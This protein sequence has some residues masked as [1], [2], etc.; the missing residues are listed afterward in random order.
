[1]NFLLN[2]LREQLRIAEGMFT[3]MG[4]EAFADRARAELVAVG[5]KYAR[6]K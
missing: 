5:G 3:E 2:C 4:M 1:M 6:S